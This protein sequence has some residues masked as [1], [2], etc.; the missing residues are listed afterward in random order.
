[1]STLLLVIDGS[2]RGSEQREVAPDLR[3]GTHA[4]SHSA[5]PR[6]QFGRPLVVELRV[7]GP[8]PAITL[9]TSRPISLAAPNAIT[10][11]TSTWIN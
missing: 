7:V 8:I 2:L 5:A 1:M 4:G 3:P 6:D 11:A 10:S 9:P